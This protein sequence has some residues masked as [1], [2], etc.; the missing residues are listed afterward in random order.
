MSAPSLEYKQARY[1]DYGFLAAKAEQAAEGLIEDRDLSDDERNVLRAGSEFLERVATGARVLTH[2]DYRVQNLT[3]AME[4]LELAVDPIE[5]LG[6]MIQD[7]DI[8]AL[9]QDVAR[10]VTENSARADRHALTT[11]DKGKVDIYRTFFDQFY[12]FIRA[13]M[14]EMNKEPL[15][16]GRSRFGAQVGR[17]A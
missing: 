7:A 13:Q 5:H 6:Q 16:G 3:G 10:T 1:L 4:A 9:L 12:L 8:S 11:E 17:I 2:G 15:L 14:N